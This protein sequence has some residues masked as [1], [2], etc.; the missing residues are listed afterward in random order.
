MLFPKNTILA[1][2]IGSI[3][4]EITSAAALTSDDSQRQKIQLKI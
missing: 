4:Q 2:F 3:E 1:N